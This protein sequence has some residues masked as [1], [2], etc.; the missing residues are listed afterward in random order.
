MLEV[1]GA[2]RSVF[3]TDEFENSS[4]VVS[5]LPLRMFVQANNEYSYSLW[6]GSKETQRAPSSAYARRS[7]VTCKREGRHSHANV[8]AAWFLAAAG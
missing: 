2:F 5:A 4:V 6:L 3:L 1:E 7:V 8:H